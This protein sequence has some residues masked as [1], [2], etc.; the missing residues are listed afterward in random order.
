MWEP[1]IAKSFN[2][3]ECPL[4]TKVERTDMQGFRRASSALHRLLLPNLG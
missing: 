3:L 4:T 1:N 2:I